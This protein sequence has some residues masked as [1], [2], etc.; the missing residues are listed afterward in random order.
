MYF[1]QQQVIADTDSMDQEDDVIVVDKH[2]VFCHEAR[3]NQALVAL[4]I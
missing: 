3:T 1:T 4:N 2:F